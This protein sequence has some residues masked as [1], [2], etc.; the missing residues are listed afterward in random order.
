VELFS[1]RP[2]TRVEI[3]ADADRA[4]SKGRVKKAVAGYRKALESD[5]TDPFVNVKLA[6]LLVRMGD[7]DGGARCFRTAAK[8]HLEAGFTDRAAAVALAATSVFPLDAGFRLELSRLNERRGRRQD[9]VQ[10][11][12]DGGTALARA[13]R[14]DAAVGLLGRALEIEPWHLGASLALV[15]VLAS[16]GNAGGA[17]RIVDGL[18]ERYRGPALKQI[19]WTAF[20]VWPGLGTFWRWL[21]AH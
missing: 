11:L 15:P 12:V 1:R 21:R 17:R 14:P 13:R 20:R 4:R 2:K 19:R 7:S 6:P 18:L 9:A 16:T 10:V 5:P 3:L 8:K